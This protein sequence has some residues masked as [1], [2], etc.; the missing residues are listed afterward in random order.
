MG[1]FGGTCKWRRK[2]FREL[3]KLT[4]IGFCGFER[5]YIGFLKFRWS[6]IV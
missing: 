1:G 3:N 5:G 6:L 4:R 2:E